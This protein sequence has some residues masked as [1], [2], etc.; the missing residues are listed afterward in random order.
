MEQKKRKKVLYY[1]NDFTRDAVVPEGEHLPEV[2]FT[3][4]PLTI[5][6]AAMYTQ[7]IV[8]SKGMV[9]GTQVHLNMISD[10]VTKWD[11][12]KPDGTQ[13]SPQD[14]DSLHRIDAFIIQRIAEEIKEKGGNLLSEDELK[15]LSTG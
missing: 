2:N 13:I 10:V 14:M 1:E 4:K 12:T 3:Y 5:I 8:D 9:G 7:K 11:V 6:Q 15:N